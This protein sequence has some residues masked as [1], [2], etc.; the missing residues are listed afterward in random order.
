MNHTTPRRILEGALIFLLSAA[1]AA[2]RELRAPR[3][4]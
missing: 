4:W 2:W 1:T 3:G